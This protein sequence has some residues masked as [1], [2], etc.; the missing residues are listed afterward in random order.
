MNA[1]PTIEDRI[2]HFPDGIPGFP[3]HRR[4]VLVELAPDAAFHE[5]RS[6]DEPGVAMLVTVPWL[7]FPDYA[8]EITEEDRL[9]LGLERP[10]DATIFCTVAVDEED[11]AGLTID[12]LGPFVVNAKA[13]IGRQ[14]VLADSEYPARARVE[15][16]AA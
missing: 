10:E 7:F 4:F 1:D 6:V 5:L 11:D 12:L 9:A 3:N 2:I 14:L 13:R 16:A 8:P 15:P